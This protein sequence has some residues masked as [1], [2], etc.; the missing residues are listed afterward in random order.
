[1]TFPPVLSSVRFSPPAT[2]SNSGP[3]RSRAYTPACL[4]RLVI[5]DGADAV[6]L[7]LSA[8]TSFSGCTVT[9]PTPTLTLDNSSVHTHPSLPPLLQ[10]P[11]ASV[12]FSA[13]LISSTARPRRKRPFSSP[14]PPAST[15]LSPL[16][17]LVSQSHVTSSANERPATPSSQP[18]PNCAAA[19]FPATRTRTRPHLGFGPVSNPAKQRTRRVL[20]ATTS[21]SDTPFPR[22]PPSR[23]SSPTA[24]AKHE[25]PSDWLDRHGLGCATLVKFVLRCPRVPSFRPSAPSLHFDFVGLD[26]I[27]IC[28]FFS[29][30][31]FPFTFVAAGCQTPSTL[32]DHLRPAA[33]FRLQR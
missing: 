21:N 16:S 1:M 22:R 15:C 5:P 10:K 32:P 17:R 33:L 14:A 8:F 13:L 25:G 12:V 26:L 9:L 20:F 31:P 29:E 7:H 3:S 28:F 2:P 30:I 27:A 18:R 4:F 24:A 6:S 11:R 23:P 19:T